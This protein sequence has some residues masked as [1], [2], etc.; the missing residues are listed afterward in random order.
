[1]HFGCFWHAF[2]AWAPKCTIL[3]SCHKNRNTWM[4][5]TYFPKLKW[6]H[7]M[8]TF[9]FNNHSWYCASNRPKKVINWPF[10]HFPSHY[11]FWKCWHI[12]ICWKKTKIYALNLQYKNENNHSTMK[13]WKRIWWKI[14]WLRSI[15]SLLIFEVVK[16]ESC[17]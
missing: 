2:F 10:F 16:K 4:S 12:Y 7:V 3:V 5:C 14:W 17:D 9:Y 15:C 1:M 6:K 11:C 8:P 13:V